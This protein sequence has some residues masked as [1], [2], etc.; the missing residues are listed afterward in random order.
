MSSNRTS[1]GVIA[2]RETFDRCR[3]GIELRDVSAQQS[4]DGWVIWGHYSCQECSK[5]ALHVSGE[6][7]RAV[8]VNGR[9]IPVILS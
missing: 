1:L 5:V 2:L 9:M 6:V 3:H 4:A 7:P 8:N